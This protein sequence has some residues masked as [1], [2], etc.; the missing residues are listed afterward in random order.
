MSIATQVKRLQDVRNQIRTKMVA[1]GLSK[2][3]DLL[4]KLAN[5][6]DGVDK[7][8]PTNNG[9]TDPEGYT[10]V[11]T[12]SRSTSTRYI[13][14]PKGYNDTNRKFTVEGVADGSYSAAEVTPTKSTQYVKITAGYLPDSKITVKAIPSTTLTVAASAWTKETSATE[15]GSYTQTVTGVTGVSTDNDIVV[16][17]GSTSEVT[18]RGVYAAGQGDSIVKF[19]AFDRPTSDISYTVYILNK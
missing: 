19:K 18:A 2:N 3:T 5:D 17:P 12:L 4:Q 11:D 1:L 10:N 7:I 8:S 14:V 16:L 6:L 15:T 13:K 9:I